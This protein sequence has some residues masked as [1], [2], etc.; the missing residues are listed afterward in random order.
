MYNNVFMY[1][2]ASSIQWILDEMRIGH[3]LSW[4]ISLVACWYLEVN[5]PIMIHNSPGDISISSFY[6]IL[7][8]I[9]MYDTDLLVN[10]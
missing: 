1:F 6:G 3:W 8:R 5:V 10:K 4:Q 7:Y 2:H 9:C